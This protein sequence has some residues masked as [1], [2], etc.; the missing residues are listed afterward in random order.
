MLNFYLWAS[1][2]CYAFC[3][4][5]TLGSYIVINLM[6]WYSFIHLLCVLANDPGTSTYM[7]R[8]Q[9]VSTGWIA[10]EIFSGG[11]ITSGEGRARGVDVG[12]N[13]DMIW[14][15]LPCHLPRSSLLCGRARF[16]G[17]SPL[18]YCRLPR[19]WP[20]PSAEVKAVDP[21]GFRWVEWG[22]LARIWIKEAV[23]RL[24][25]APRWRSARCPSPSI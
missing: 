23:L 1:H 2:R 24:Q 5:Y 15:D 25:H 6:H 12:W 13:L 19:C 21:A 10:T 9:S 14:V 7:H 17:G 4:N 11:A 8:I 16:G 20:W 18:L 22:L 3:N